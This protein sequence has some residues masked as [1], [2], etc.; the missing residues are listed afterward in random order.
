MKKIIIL[1]WITLIIIFLVT[2]FFVFQLKKVH[3]ENKMKDFFPENHPTSRTFLKAEE[4]SAIIT[5]Y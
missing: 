3:F 1:S 4:F 2:I 5:R